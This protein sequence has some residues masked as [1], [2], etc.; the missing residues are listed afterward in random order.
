MSDDKTK[1]QLS[2]ELT[3]VRRQLAE[4][5]LRITAL[6]KSLAM[7]ADTRQALQQRQEELE[8]II[9]TSPALLAYV[10]REL[11][12]IHVNQAYAEWYGASREHLAGK[13][14]ADILS[15]A[16]YAGILPH[17]N[18]VLSGVPV[19]FENI[20]YTPAGELRAVRA[21][22]TPQIA[23][24]GFVCAFLA[25]VEDIT[26]RK[27][28]EQELR[29]K[30]LAITTAINAI[31][32]S[33]PQGNLTYVNAAFL[34]LWRDDGDEVLGRSV[35]S[36][37]QKPEAAAAVIQALLAQGQWIGE[38]KARRTDG[39]TFDAQ[40]VAHMVMDVKDKPLGMMASFIDITERKQAEAAL[41]ESEARFRRAVFNAPFPMIIHA[42]DGEVIDINEA[43][44]ELSGY[45]HDDIRTISDWIE[46]A[47]EHR[48]EVVAADIAR[49]F[50]TTEKRIN[51]GEYTIKT[52]G[53][54][55]RVWEFS[56]APLG[57]L[58]DGRR[59]M[60]SIAIDVT[61][62]KAVERALYEA[63]AE[64]HARN[65]ELDAFGHTVAHDLKNLLS[66]AIGYAEVLELDFTT[67]PEDRVRKYLR[68]IARDSRKM[69]GI[70]DELLVLS[71]LRRVAVPLLPVDMQP[72]IA[73][74]LQRLADVIEAQEATV[75]GPDTW[76][77]ALG[78]SPWIEEVWVNYLSNALKYGGTP[79]V[80]TLGA[81]IEAGGKVRF[82]VRD[83]GPGL[84][85]EECQRLFTPFTRLDQVH[86]RGYGLGLSIVKRI[87][88]KLGGEVAVNSEPGKGSSFSFTLPSSGAPA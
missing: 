41:R 79:P 22:Y 71:G 35:I 53:N 88:E 56:S 10:N 66:R 1:D 37:W 84:T 62:R 48:K 30:D 85:P 11:R 8:Q 67:L 68:R 55:E 70:V 27:K 54:E 36:F 40:V 23:P 14:V 12:Y 63:N 59:L 75:K 29:I 64:L 78:Y 74:A 83:N 49:L 60:I 25:T 18:K 6:E 51:E 20:S 46:K 81:Q 77:M 3:E 57:Q 43:W 80:V 19:A 38:L 17:V 32:F 87:V 7:L 21:S 28:I 45:T 86:I 72:V 15:P 4:A 58:P 13:R 2:E 61:D 47:Y 31:A 5:Q 50:E 34:E 9:D 24:Q 52:R 26:E 76:P 44:T 82:W 73:E 16:S 33:D 65:E 42:E 69:N 39:S